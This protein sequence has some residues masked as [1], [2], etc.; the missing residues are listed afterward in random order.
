PV[1]EYGNERGYEV[2]S[3]ITSVVEYQ[4][5]RDTLIGFGGSNNLFDVGT[6]TVGKLNEMDENTTEVKVE[7]AVLSDKPNQTHYRAL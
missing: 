4:K 6:P 1:G 5:D 2:Y 3:P 7:L